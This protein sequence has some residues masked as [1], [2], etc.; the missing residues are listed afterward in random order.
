MMAV[1]RA[2]HLWTCHHVGLSG[3]NGAYSGD[4][5]GSNVDRSAAQWLNF[6]LGSTGLT[7]NAHER[8]FDPAATNAFW[9]YMPSLMVNCSGDMLMGFSGSSPNDFIGAYCSWLFAGNSASVGPFVIQQGTANSNLI[10]GW[11]D[12]S[13]TSLDPVD[14]WSFW[15]VQEYADGTQ[16][17]FNTPWSTW[18]IQLSHLP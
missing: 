3:A 6:Q 8:V 17:A 13:Y 18:I 2:G 15:T 10:Y 11:G 5:T 16:N 4:E 9:Y 7:Y 14:D 12:Y 1:I